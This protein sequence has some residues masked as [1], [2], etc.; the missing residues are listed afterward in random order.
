[1]P[2][3]KDTE[4]KETETKETDTP[5]EETGDTKSKKRLPGWAWGV[6]GT[7][8]MLPLLFIGMKGCG[9]GGDGRRD[10]KDEEQPKTEVVVPEPDEKVG[11]TNNYYYYGDVNQ[12]NITNSGNGN[13]S[14]EF[15]ATHTE[16]CG[17]GD[18]NVAGGKSS[19]AAQKSRG[20]QNSGNAG[21]RPQASEGKVVVKPENSGNAGYRPQASEG[22]VVVVKP[23]VIEKTCTF[24][25]TYPCVPCVPC[26]GN[27]R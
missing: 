15:T 19:N 16:S 12:Q 22:K 18:V 10:G 20:S 9:K 13:V 17:N 4:V 1:M 3:T 21:Y 27:S 24:T 5:V 8:L 26:D 14:A 2:E 6:I 7:A 11:V 23:E 25:I